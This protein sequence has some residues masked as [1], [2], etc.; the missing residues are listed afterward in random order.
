MT[1][2]FLLMVG[3]VALLAASSNL[4]ATT[5]VSVTGGPSGIG[6]GIFPT[7]TVAISFTVGQFYSNVSIRPDLIGTNS[8][9]SGIAYLTNQI[10][11]GT[12]LLNQIASS[13]F[14]YQGAPFQPVIQNVSL[15]PGTYFLVLSAITT[16]I[17]QGWSTSIAPVT[18]TDVGASTPFGTYFSSGTNA[19]APSNQFDFLST[20]NGSTTTPRFIVTSDSPVPEPASWIL[21]S[22][23]FFLLIRWGSRA[24]PSNLLLK[25]N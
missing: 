19:F 5:I 23:A 6:A 1:Y 24:T 21:T 3:T 15:N 20:F 25:R 17:P 10:G 9:F 4:Y 13:P 11:S 14:T 7:Q 22:S 12:T 2:K 8:N 16:S 18:V